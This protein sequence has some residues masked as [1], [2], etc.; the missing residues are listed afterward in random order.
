M[1][2]QGQWSEIRD[3]RSEIRLRSQKQKSGSENAEHRTPNSPKCNALTR[4]RKRSSVLRGLESVFIIRPMAMR[5]VGTVTFLFTDMEGSTRAW[6]AH[7]KETHVAL[8]C[9]DEIV[10]KAIEANRGTII[11]ERGEGD[12][13]FA[14]FERA[15]DAVAAA[16]DLQSALSKQKW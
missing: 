13:I 6:E 14:V 9:H 5:P 2:R 3:R 12:S 8:Q 15:S 11:L 4:L 1:K 10:T 16:C 7:P